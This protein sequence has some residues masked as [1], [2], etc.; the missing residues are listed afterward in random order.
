M[1]G[2]TTY[3]GPQDERRQ[4]VPITGP[5]GKQ[6]QTGRFDPRRNLIDRSFQRCW[7]LEYLGIADDRKK[8]MDARPWNRPR[9]AALGQRANGGGCRRMPFGVRSM[10]VH[11]NVR[12]D[13]DQPRAP[14]GPAPRSFAQSRTVSQPATRAASV[15]PPRPKL[16]SRSRN[17]GRRAPSRS[18][19]DSPCSTSARKVVPCR[20]A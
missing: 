3:L 4:S 18:T 15:R 2:A 17:G 14:F 11:E 5:F 20:A 16:A 9:C 12:I 6:R 19:A 1:N 8:L 7:M 10:C 13:C